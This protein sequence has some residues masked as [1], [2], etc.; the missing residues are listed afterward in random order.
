MGI[1]SRVVNGNVV[2]AVTGEVDTEAAPKLRAALIT[3]IDGTA[4][5]CVLDLTRVDF[6]DSA[7][8][9]TLITT[10]RYAETHGKSL[11]IAVDSNSTVIRPIE[12]TGLDV[13]LRLYHT[14]DEALEASN[15][16]PRAER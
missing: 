5:A 9:A 2:L 14:V 16:P 13:V 11:R 1:V 15:R 8:L 4:D 12:V 6:L 10:D 3:A 7:G